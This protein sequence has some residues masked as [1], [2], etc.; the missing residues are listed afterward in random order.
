MKIIL[1]D[2]GMAYLEEGDVGY[3]V[4]TTALSKENVDKV[5]WPDDPAS[6]SSPWIERVPFAGRERPDDLLAIAE[7]L[8]AEA[9]DIHN[10]P[11][12][13]PS[14]NEVKDM[15]DE[16]IKTA[17]DID[18]SNLAAPYTDKE[19]ESWTKQE[20][21]A[22][23][24][25]LDNTNATPFIDAM[26]TVRTTITKVELINR[27]VAKADAFANESGKLTGKKH[28]IE[29]QIADAYQAGDITALKNIQW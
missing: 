2:E 4:D 3:A 1:V 8:M 25:L 10:T 23:A 28:F 16:E 26:L 12:P 20:S 15:K 9:V 6:K 18:M 11:S 14:L 19:R 13:E 21:E 17:Y 27:I 24:W 29:E 5:V 7:T 22:R